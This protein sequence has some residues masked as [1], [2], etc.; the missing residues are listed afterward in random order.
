MMPLIRP[1]SDDGMNMFEV[2]FAAFIMFFVLTAVLGLVVT[3]TEMG[4]NAKQRNMMSNTIAARMEYVRSLPFEQVAIAG[5]GSEGVLP[6]TETFTRGGFDVVVSYQVTQGTAGTKNVRITVSCSAPGGATVTSSAFSVVRD[7]DLTITMRPGGSGTEPVIEFMSGTSAPDSTVYNNLVWSPAGTLRLD[8]QATGQGEALIT[9]LEMYVVTEGAT[10]LTYLKDGTSLYSDTAQWSYDPGAG[11]ERETFIWHTKQVELDDQ[12]HT[13]APVQDGW[14]T[15]RVRAGD[16]NGEFS[17]LDIRFFVDNDP[18][19]DTGP[20]TVTPMTDVSCVAEW[21]PAEGALT[22]ALNHYKQR[23][24]GTGSYTEPSSFDASA[25]IQT[26]ELTYPI[27]TTPFSRYVATV[28]GASMRFT[29]TNVSVSEPFVSKPLLTGT[30]STTT[31]GSGSK[32]RATTVS[33][34]SVTPPQF[35]CSGD[36][37]YSWYVKHDVLTGGAWD[38]VTQTYVPG[39]ATAT[40]SDTQQ[41]TQGISA[42]K[43]YH[44]KCVVSF[45]PL[46][47][48]GGSPRTVETNIVG[49]TTGGSVTTLLPVA[50]W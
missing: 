6:G 19:G 44:Y 49:P 32:K 42:Y 26:G 3:T 14:Q 39:S 28:A 20:I 46:G 10:E 40:L 45:T 41:Y 18:P 7:R 30:S 50:G 37:T 24:D 48:G 4:V 35:P 25:P 16:S 8:V 31:S 9:S 2:V 17:T 21:G 5:G 15:V 34:L 38:L 47:Y 33:N 36:L 11:T 12:G 22:Y 13:V 43:P 27:P 1:R 23:I 29:S